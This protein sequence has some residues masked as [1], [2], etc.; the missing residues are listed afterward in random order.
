MSEMT[1]LTKIV[2]LL[3]SSK[4]QGYVHKMAQSTKH[5]HQLTKSKRTT[6]RPARKTLAFGKW[7]EYRGLTEVLPGLGYR[8]SDVRSLHKIDCGSCNPTLL[9]CTYHV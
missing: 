1:Y 9:P 7:P 6:E 2:Q 3:E 5:R 4:L 8:L